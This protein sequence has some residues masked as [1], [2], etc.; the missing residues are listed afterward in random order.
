MRDLRQNLCFLST[1]SPSLL[2]HASSSELSV[3]GTSLLE[4]LTESAG[5]SGDHRI[6]KV[7]LLQM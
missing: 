7:P 5:R 6:Q 3:K 2:L 1:H 4:G